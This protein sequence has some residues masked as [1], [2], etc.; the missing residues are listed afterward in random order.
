VAE[1]I[2]PVLPVTQGKEL[3]NAVSG[4]TSAIAEDLIEAAKRHIGARYSLGSTG[5]KSFDCSGFT[6]YVFKRLGI[7]LKRS[8]REQVTQGEAV[9]SKSE[10]QPGDLVFFGHRGRKAK[11]VSHVGIV[12]DVD[13]ETG[14]FSFIHAS[15]SRGVRI[16][17]STDD[18]WSPR[19]VGGRRIIGT[20]VNSYQS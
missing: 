17:S 15:T 10:L 2:T 7:T 13:A 9:A 1:V 8:S 5:P 18:Y 16:D 11:S 12:T 20:N 14:L 4:F 3:V 6:S 19:F